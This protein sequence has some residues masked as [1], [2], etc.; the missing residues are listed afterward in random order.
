MR[1]QEQEQEQRSRDA[2]FH[3]GRWGR[4]IRAEENETTFRGRGRKLSLL[5]R[6][7]DQSDQ[8]VKVC[9]G[10]RRVAHDEQRGLRT[11]GRERERKREGE[12]AEA[13]A[14]GVRRGREGSKGRRRNESESAWDVCLFAQ[15]VSD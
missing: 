11:G 14:G 10:V 3:R 7:S 8:E 1:E 13:G 6:T 5:D 15:R 9:A 4:E 12:A 2:K